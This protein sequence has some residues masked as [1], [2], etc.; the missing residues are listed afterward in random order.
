MSL[1]SVLSRHLIDPFVIKP[2]L[3]LP[4]DAATRLLTVEEQVN[5][6][7][8]VDHFVQSKGAKAANAVTGAVLDMT[9]VVKGGFREGDIV[10]RGNSPVTTAQSAM[11]TSLSEGLKTHDWFIRKSAVSHA[12]I[13]AR[14][15]AG[16]LRVVQMIAGE[17]PPE[18]LQHLTPLQKKLKATFVHE[19]SL[20]DFFNLKEGH[21]STRSTVMR[22][23]DP[24][25]AAAAARRAHELFKTQITP[26]GTHPWYSQVPHSLAPGG[27]GGVCS[28][29]VD[30][31]YGEGFSNRYHI[32]TTPL[33]FVRSSQ[34]TQVGDRAVTEIRAAG[35]AV[36]GTLK[37]AK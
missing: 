28:T 17:T 26:E 18:L 4:A 37:L 22:P 8:V 13:V 33:D 9:P 11:M 15:D 34:V 16:E 36:E 10:M 27:R 12:G 7:M 20:S 35:A 30:L 1:K 21:V 14:N 25:Q 32:P 5:G 29:F 2:G 3:H 24:Q 23:K 31:A 19:D 6:K